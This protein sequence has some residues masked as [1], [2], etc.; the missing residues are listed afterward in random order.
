MLFRIQVLL[1]FEIVTAMVVLANPFLG[2]LILLLLLLMRPQDD[3]PNMQQLHF[4]LVMT[5]CIV[6][7]TL[8]RLGR[9]IVAGHRAVSSLGLPMLYFVLMYISAL[10]N[11]YTMISRE[12]LQSM[13]VTLITLFAMLT[14]IDNVDRF[15]AVVGVMLLAGLYYVRMAVLNPSFLRSSI[16]GVEYTRLNFRNLTNFGNPNY[17]ALFV[18]LLLFLA[19]GALT[20][21][22]K[23]LLTLPLMGA[24]AGFVYVFLKCQSRGA[25]VAF[26]LGMIVFWVTHPRKNIS[27]IACGL[28]VGVG[29]IFMAPATFFER[30]TT[31][32]NYQED[33]SSIGRLQ[34]WGIAYTVIVSHPVLGIGPNNFEGTY[35]FNSEHNTYVQAAAEL[36]I[37]GLMVLLA[38]VLR[39]FHQCVVARRLTKPRPG[40]TMN[41]MHI[42]AS[43]LMAC[44]TQ[45]MVQGLFNGFAYREFMMTTVMLCSLARLIAEHDPVLVEARP[46]PVV[47]WMPPRRVRPVLAPA[48][49]APSGNS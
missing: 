5:M 31:I 27:L 16:S 47:P 9:V 28:V 3:R 39:S 21:G 29:L 18:C 15:M 40:A 41:P 2:T 22:Y 14:F 25:V 48:G 32:G 23:K 13:F 1:G 43:A 33:N 20:S 10:A 42:M 11:G 8:S 6:I 37:P 38:M 49:P 34:L 35:G 44:M 12:E 24:A 30:L 17:L 4:P 45:L 7:G 36:G 46:A 19:F 26:A